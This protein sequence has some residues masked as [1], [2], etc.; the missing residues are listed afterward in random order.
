LVAL[1]SVDPVKDGIADGVNRMI[2]AIAVCFQQRDV[3]NADALAFTLNQLVNRYESVCS[4]A[5]RISGIVTYVDAAETDYWTMV[6]R[7]PLPK[8]FMRFVLQ[9]LSAAPRLRSFILDLLATL[10]QKQL[11]KNPQQWKGWLLCAEQTAPDSFPILLKVCVL[12]LSV[13]ISE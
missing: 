3:F 12:L 1:H 4:T 9:T 8:L 6:T 5:C 7:N 13:V 2:A 10:A 11:W